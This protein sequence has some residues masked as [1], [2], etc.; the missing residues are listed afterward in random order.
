MTSPPAFTNSVR[1]LSTPAAFPFFFLYGGASALS[2][3]GKLFHQLVGSL[4]AVLL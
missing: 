4:A 1:M 3:A 2:D